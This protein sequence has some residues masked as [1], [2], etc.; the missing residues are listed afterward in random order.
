[1]TGPSLL[2]RIRAYNEC[3]VTDCARQ[4]GEGTLFCGEHLADMWRNRLDRQP[5]GTFVA[6]RRFT[7]RDFTGTV[8]L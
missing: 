3:A 4:R 2:D 6:R 7:A 5:D 8:A 1:M